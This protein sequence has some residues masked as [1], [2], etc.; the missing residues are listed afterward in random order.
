[1]TV[2]E[3]EHKECRMRANFVACHKVEPVVHFLV[4]VFFLEIQDK[5]VLFLTF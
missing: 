1:M 3:H 4:F 5:I 2:A